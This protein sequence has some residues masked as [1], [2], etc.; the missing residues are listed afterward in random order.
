MYRIVYKN[1]EM[2]TIRNKKLDKLKKVCY[3]SCTI[4]KTLKLLIIVNNN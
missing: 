1:K 4:K 2:L 3:N